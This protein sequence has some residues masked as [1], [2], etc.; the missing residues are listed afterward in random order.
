L[1]AAVLVPALSVIGAA[2]ALACVRQPLVVVQPQSSGPPGT[3]VT[4]AGTG[5][6]DDRT[7]LRW[8]G[9]DGP[10]LGTATGPEFSV[11]VTIPEAPGGLYSLVAVLRSPDGSIG[12]AVRAS[13][14]ITAGTAPAGATGT[15]TAAPAPTGTA[16][17]PT[18]A[19]GAAAPARAV[20]H[21]RAS[22][23]VPGLVLA[24]VGGAAAAAALVGFGVALGQRRERALT[25]PAQPPA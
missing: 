8:N 23:R 2:G 14:Q 11:P 3:R 1:L 19:A 5:F 4:V 20:A 21:D 17:A 10:L 7:E 25:A 15:G 22:S 9:Q 12:N 24:G 18:G 6:S 13:F 16:A